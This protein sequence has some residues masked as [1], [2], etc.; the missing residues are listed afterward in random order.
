M[1]AYEP[2]TYPPDS[3]VVIG[4]R[5]ARLRQRYGNDAPQTVA[6]RRDL[7]AAQIAV[8]V[9]KAMADAPPLTDEQADR[10]AEIIRTSGGAR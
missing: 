7:A 5:V 6:A 10:L 1:S 8:A 9:A 4:P 2:V 3:P